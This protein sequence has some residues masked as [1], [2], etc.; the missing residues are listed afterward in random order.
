MSTVRVTCIIP[1]Y[2]EAATITGVIRAARACPLV[3]EVIVVSDGSSDNTA[4]LAAWAGAHRVITLLRNGGKGR[5]V[6]EAVREAGGEVILLLDADL[7]GLRPAHLGQLLAPVLQGEAEMAVAEFSEDRLHRWMHPL[8]GQRAIRRSLLCQ[9]GRLERTGFGFEIALDRAARTQGAATQR[10]SWQG[11]HHRSKREKY[12]TVAG[13]RLKMR[14][15]SDLARQ[16]IRPRRSPPMIIFLALALIVLVSALPIFFLHPSRASAQSFPPARMPAP[17]DRIL[18]I[19]AHPDD[20]VIGAG[21]FMAT[22]ARL[23][24]PVSVL[25]V[26]NGDS[27]RLAAAVIT[28]RVRPTA[29]QL[30]AEG[31]IR[32]RETVEALAR[33]GVPSSRVFFLGFPDRG[34]EAVMH[35]AVPY[36][37]PYTGLQAARY[38]DVVGPDAPY[39]ARAAQELVGRVVRGIRPTLIVT[40]APFDR[41]PDHRT[42]ARL[43]DVVRGDVPV[44]AF[45]VHAAGFPRPLRLARRDPLTVPASLAID[46]AWRWV[47]FDVA[48][49]LVL[50]KQHALDAYQSQLS[51]PYLRLLLASFIRT[52]ELFAVR[53]R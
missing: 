51:T 9:A 2:N 44:Y 3:D 7:V 48:P 10:V 36:L 15:S 34:L 35:S 21:G 42:V 47:R 5:A 24:V 8:S 43:V 29:D 50:A 33:L 1:A 23:G 53:E 28:R 6:L 16:A 52:N 39:T 45:L 11:V 13:L 31:R 40:H 18:V 14:A 32:Q 25:V 20:E 37:S 27:N 19:V 46:P 12:G 49:D 17:D 4:V 26:T 30:I 41:H 38:P 22:A